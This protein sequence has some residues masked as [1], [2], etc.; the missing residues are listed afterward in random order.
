[1]LYRDFEPGE[2]IMEDEP[3]LVTREGE[4][5]E[6][7]LLLLSILVPLSI[8]GNIMSI[9]ISCFQVGAIFDRFGSLSQEEQDTLLSLF[10]PGQ[11]KVIIQ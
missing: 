10:D 1:M 3:L 4:K 11:Y 6:A 5:V 9:I 8:G 2:V 7:Q